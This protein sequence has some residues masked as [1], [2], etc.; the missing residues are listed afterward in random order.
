MKYVD[1]NSYIKQI[2]YKWGKPNEY[3]A[4]KRRIGKSKW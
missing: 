2:K 4:H 1:S 3:K